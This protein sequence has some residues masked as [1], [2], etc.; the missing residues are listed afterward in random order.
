MTR[1]VVLS[2]RQRRRRRRH[3]L[4]W[5][6]YNAL[7]RFIWQTD[8]LQ[9]ITCGTTAAAPRRA[10]VTRSA[11]WRG[12]SVSFCPCMPVS[13][14]P[15][16]ARTAR[17]RRA[18]TWMYPAPCPGTQWNQHSDGEIC[19]WVASESYSRTPRRPLPTGCEAVR[20]R[21]TGP[22]S[23]CTGMNRCRCFYDGGDGDDDDG[24]GDG[25][26]LGTLN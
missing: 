9:D 10:L 26:C 16:V 22:S 11:P 1:S 6:S 14:C 12:T 17:D 2:A 5:D 24:G 4:S 20:V 25:V 18:P 15:T 13:C 19:V 8:R 3:S 21:T 23:C 7:Q